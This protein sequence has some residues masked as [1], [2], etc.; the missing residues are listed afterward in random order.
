MTLSLILS[1]SH[2]LYHSLPF[3]ALSTS[4]L[5][6]WFISWH[7]QKAGRINF[8]TQINPINPRCGPNGLKFN[9]R[10]PSALNSAGREGLD[11]HDL[12]QAQ[13]YCQ[14]GKSHVGFPLA[15]WRQKTSIDIKWWSDGLIHLQ[16]HDLS[17][18]CLNSLT[19]TWMLSKGTKCH[20]W[21]DLFH[22]SFFNSS[23]MLYQKIMNNSVRKCLFCNSA[24]FC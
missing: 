21:F 1:L 12:K 11:L 6:G 13:V 14:E 24:T 18:H 2:I 3:A 8:L 19:P 17:V 5:A 7:L 16:C 23:E 10:S 22:A 9:L 20:A 15:Q 4:R